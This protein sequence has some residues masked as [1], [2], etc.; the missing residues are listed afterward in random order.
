MHLVPWGVLAQ[1]SH[2]L[3]TSLHGLD[4][5][6]LAQGTKLKLHLYQKAS[7]LIMRRKEHSRSESLSAI[8]CRPLR[9][10]KIKFPET[11]FRNTNK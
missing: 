11:K 9:L 6:L 2:H 3:R 7:G 4:V 10:R 1:L 8:L 5:R